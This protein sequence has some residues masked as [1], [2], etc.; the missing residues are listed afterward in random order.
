MEKNEGCRRGD[1]GGGG[2]DR[3]ADSCGE[4]ERTKITMKGGRREGRRRRRGDR[5]G[6]RRERGREEEEEE[7][8]RGAMPGRGVQLGCCTSNEERESMWVWDTGGEAPINRRAAALHLSTRA[9][10]NTGTLQTMFKVTDVSD[11]RCANART[12]THE[13]RGAEA[14][15]I[16]EPREIS[17]LYYPGL[18][19]AVVAYAIRQRG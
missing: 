3:K 10:I 13:D 12:S 18:R 15:T 6:D 5:R 19:L 1:E 2:N 16:R 7:K 17:A 4:T 14:G 9:E 11:A 8:M